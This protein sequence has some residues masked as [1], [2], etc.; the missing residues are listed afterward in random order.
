MAG[1]ISLYIVCYVDSI[2]FIILSLLFIV[3]FM[4]LFGGIFGYNNIGYELRILYLCSHHALA[5]SLLRGDLGLWLFNK[6]DVV[7]TSF[8]SSGCHLIKSYC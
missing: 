4:Q 1:F 8:C 3:P 2:T 5:T 7:K 6:M